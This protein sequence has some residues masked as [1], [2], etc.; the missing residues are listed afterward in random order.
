[1]EWARG[2]IAAG[3][4]YQLNLTRR[5]RARAPVEPWPLY[6]RLVS[7][8]HPSYAALIDTGR[9]V[10]A[11]ASP[12]LFFHWRDG[13]LACRPMKGTAARGR[14]DSEDREVAA[15]LAASAKDQ[16]EN[17]MIVDLVRNDLGRLAEY[18]TVTVTDLFRLEPYPTMWQLTSGVTARTRSGTKLVDVFRALFPC[19]SVTGAPKRRTMELITEVE[20]CGRGVYCGAV[21]FVGPTEARFNVAIRTAVLDRRTGEAVYGSGGG[22]VWDSDPGRELAEADHKAG[23]LAAPLDQFDLVETALDRV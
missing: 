3:D 7:A 6:Q 1:M 4:T 19:G 12:E 8:Q 11:S 15:M 9:L 14:T 13:V 10:V 21:G 2:H 23:I 20:D 22:I 5:W 17:V 16:A 18:G